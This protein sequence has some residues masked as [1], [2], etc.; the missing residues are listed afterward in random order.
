MA[1]SAV[2]ITLNEEENMERCLESLRFADE[3]VVLDSFSADGTVEIARRY[4]DNISCR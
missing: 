1:L 3:I 2:G 4:T